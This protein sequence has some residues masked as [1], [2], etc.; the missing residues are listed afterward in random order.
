MAASASP[1]GSAY[2]SEEEEE[3]D[4]ERCYLEKQ[5]RDG[6]NMLFVEGGVAKSRSMVSLSSNSDPLNQSFSAVTAQQARNR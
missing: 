3:E 5:K 2:T 4:G 1:S 6:E